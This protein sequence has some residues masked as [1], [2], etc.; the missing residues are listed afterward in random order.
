MKV[1]FIGLGN[2]GSGMANLLKAGHEVTVY[3]RTPGKMPPLVDQGAHPAEVAEACQGDAVITMLAD[4]GLL[5]DK[6]FKPPGFA[7]PLRYKD[8]RLT[9][10]A[11][12]TLR[13][14]MPLG[15]LLRDRFLT[16]LARGGAELDWSAISQLAALDA[17]QEDYL[18][19][20][21]PLQTTR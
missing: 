13:V 16:L 7:A 5:V 4:D 11:A 8:I 10:D 2:M 21:N 18:I 3:N 19:G 15:S 9:L 17:G 12:A 20:P 1:G 6:K 14:P